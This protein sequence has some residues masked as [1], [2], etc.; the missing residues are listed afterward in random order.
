M[1]RAPNPE[2]RAYFLTARRNHCKLITFQTATESRM[3]G[4]DEGGR[5]LQILSAPHLTLLALDAR[6]A[7]LQAES[8]TAFFNAIAVMHEARWPPEPFGQAACDWARD[9]LKHDLD[10]Q[11]WYGWVMLANEGELKPPRIV[12]MAAVIGRPDEEGDVE[13]AFGVTP[14]MQGRGYAGEA[15]Q[16]LAR[17]ALEN[18]AKRVLAHLDAEDAIAAGML[19]SSG[20]FDTCEPPYPGVARFAL[21]AA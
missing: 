3:V 8:R 20:F 17:W 11:G 13:L 2:I 12:G 7:A 4:A 15:V 5:I 1:L 9:H 18:G 21:M 19:E 6:L 16:V 10:G 14:E